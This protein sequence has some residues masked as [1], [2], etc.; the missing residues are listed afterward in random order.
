MEVGHLGT[1]SDDG[2]FAQC[3]FLQNIAHGRMTLPVASAVGNMVLPYY[4]VRDE[5]FPL[6]T[7]VMRPFAKKKVSRCKQKV[8]RPKWQPWGH[9]FLVAVPTQRKV[10]FPCAK[11]LFLS[12]ANNVITESITV[13]LWQCHVVITVKKHSTI[14][15]NDSFSLWRGDNLTEAIAGNMLFA[16]HLSH[17]M[18]PLLLC[19]L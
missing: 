19:L 16:A 14:V 18:I 12:K 13:N 17:S 8:N 2:V 9:I 15:H 6:K 4:F 1:E 3:N 7:F 10:S 5:A 11:Y